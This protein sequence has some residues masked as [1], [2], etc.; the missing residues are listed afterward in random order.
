MNILLL[1][2]MISWQDMPITYEVKGPVKV[3]KALAAAMTKWVIAGSGEIDFCKEGGPVK[4]T[5]LYTKKWHKDYHESAI[6]APVHDQ[7]GNIT[8]AFIH[9]NARNDSTSVMFVS[10]M[11]N[12]LSNEDVLRLQEIYSYD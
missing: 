7:E 5:V 4:L 3:K 2:A 8:H 11:V 10:T 9:I 1:V 12:E 6:S